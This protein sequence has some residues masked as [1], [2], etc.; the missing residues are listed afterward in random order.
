MS[1]TKYQVDK[2]ALLALLLTVFAW[3]PLL[4]PYYFDAHDTRQSLFFTIEFFQGV[5][6]GYLYPRWG[7][8][9]GLGR[10]YPIFVFYPP[11]SLY[12]TQ[13]FRF[14]GL[15]VVASVKAAYVTAFLV[16]AAGTYRLTRCWFGR[17]AGLVA[18]VAYTY[19][20]Y[21]LLDVYV[22]A[23]VAEFW[24]LALFP[25]AL[26]AAVLLVRAPSVRRMAG[27][28]LTY[29]GLI[30]MHSPTALLFT[31]L[32]GLFMLLELWH[33]WQDDGRQSALRAVGLTAGS[34]VLGIWI[35]VGYLVP[36]LAELQ[37]IP[38]EQWVGG[39]YQFDRQFVYPGQFLSPFW[40]FGYAVEGPNDG[41]SFQLGIVGVG[42]GV[43]ACWYAVRGVFDR[44][45]T[46][47]VLGCAVALVLVLIGMTPASALFWQTLPLA[48]F[49][50]FPWRLLAVAIALLA[51]L[52]GAAVEA[53]THV[54]NYENRVAPGTLLAVGLLV[55]ASYSYTVPQFTPASAR[56]E[57]PLALFDMEYEHPDM[58]G[59]VGGVE[60][61][62]DSPLIEQYEAGETPTKIRL[63]YGEGQVRQTTYTGLAMEADVEATTEVTLEIV[64]YLYPGWR[65]W[66]DG[67]P[68]P[69]HTVGPHG[70]MALDVPPGSHHVV[71]RFTDT[72]L[73]RYATLASLAGILAAIGLVVVGRR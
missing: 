35:A 26:L 60:Q 52:S 51:L 28:A 12:V 15:G 14:V 20:P 34:I 30:L 49:V 17:Q 43:I 16:G 13:A 57:S 27:F 33:R 19:L 31:P 44:R 11:L 37:H 72:P 56:Q 7:P 5:A 66:I 70:H 1:R 55:L 41:M 22:R 24:A 32:I 50:Q 42:L 64:T 6:D 2:Y 47:L 39:L 45:R 25:W 10:G 59:Y 73:R 65:A 62:T 36:N 29:G 69:L 48:Q 53:L 8:D 68:A 58:V 46:V 18:A 38:T 63:L 3:A 4:S 61:P 9:F 67:E 21:R 23:A 54:T 71:V 40:G